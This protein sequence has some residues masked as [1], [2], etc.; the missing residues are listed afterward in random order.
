M[1][2]S[3]GEYLVIETQDIN[4]DDYLQ[5]LSGLAVELGGPSH[6]EYGTGF[7]A[8]RALKRVIP[9]TK[10]LISNKYGYDDSNLDLIIDANNL[11]F[12]KNSLDIV[13]A[14]YLP[15][16]LWPSLKAEARLSLKESGLLV[17]TGITDE[18]IQDAINMGF[19][20][21]RAITDNSPEEDVDVGV[22][23]VIFLNSERH[24][25]MNYSQAMS[26]MHL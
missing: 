22:W 13:L 2:K 6:N 12:R 3:A 21:L 25:Y 23:S 19:T 8:Y 24:I 20:I 18:E 9:P 15:F 5:N 26:P 14:S 16:H 7:D 1:S 11:P 4:V 10:L 17:V